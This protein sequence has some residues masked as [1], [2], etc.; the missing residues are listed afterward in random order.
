MSITSNVVL[1]KSESLSIAMIDTENILVSVNGNL[2]KI[3]CDYDILSSLLDNIDGIKTY[4]EIENIYKLEY[5]KEDI[6][7]FVGVLL[8]EEIIEI[9]ENR[10]KIEL[11]KIALLGNGKLAR[12]IKYNLRDVSNISE[13]INIG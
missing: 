5:S 10:K 6:S 8:S 1:K 11:I 13:C 4:G 12:R 7:D 2:K 3:E 9:L